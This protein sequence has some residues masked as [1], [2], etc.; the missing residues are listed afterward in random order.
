V[1]TIRV[2]MPFSASTGAGMNVTTMFPAAMD[3]TDG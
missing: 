2:A 3:D 1:K